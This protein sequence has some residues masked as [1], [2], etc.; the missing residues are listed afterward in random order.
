MHRGEGVVDPDRVDEPIHSPAIPRG[1][2]RESGFRFLP[3]SE[4][5]REKIMLQCWEKQH[6]RPGPNALVR[7][8]L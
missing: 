4:A 8:F 3:L 7:V 1:G 5:I 6:L 2:R